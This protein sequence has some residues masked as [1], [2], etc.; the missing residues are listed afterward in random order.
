MTRDL[1]IVQLLSGAVGAGVLIFWP[2]PAGKDDALVVSIVA[3]L[4]LVCLTGL[5]IL[6]KKSTALCQNQGPSSVSSVGG[7]RCTKPYARPES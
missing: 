7:R 3:V 2:S 6:H 1:L 5:W 4:W